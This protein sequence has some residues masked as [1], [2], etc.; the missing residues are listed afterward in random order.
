MTDV[1]HL[2]VTTD[3]D[4]R[5]AV[6]AFREKRAPVFRAGVPRRVMRGPRA[7]W[8]YDRPGL[9]RKLPGSALSS[10]PS[11]VAR[12]CVVTKVSP[13]MLTTIMPLMP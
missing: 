8:P 2:Q 1:Q 13:S 12:S 7:R 9:K 11:S 4:V 6:T 10:G 3:A 5:E